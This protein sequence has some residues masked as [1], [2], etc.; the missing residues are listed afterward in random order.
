MDHRKT[1]REY[2]R[3]S[4]L[5]GEAAGISG[6]YKTNKQLHNNYRSLAFVYELAAHKHS[7]LHHELNYGTDPE[8]LNF[9]KLD[10]QHSDNYLKRLHNERHDILNNHNLHNEH[11]KIMYQAEENL[12][13]QRY[14]KGWR[15]RMRLESLC[16]DKSKID[17]YQ[18]LSDHYYYAGS[19]AAPKI[20]SRHRQKN[21]V[22][23]R[24]ESNNLD[25]AHHYFNAAESFH[26]AKEAVLA[27]KTDRE[28]HHRDKGM[29]HIRKMKKLIN[30]EPETYKW[31]HR[32]FMKRAASAV[33]FFAKIDNINPSRR[34]ARL[35]EDKDE[36][37]DNLRKKRDHYHE[38]SFLAYDDADKRASSGRWEFEYHPIYSDDDDDLADHYERIANRYNGAIE[39]HLLGNH[40]RSKIEE[41]GAERSISRLN[42]FLNDTGKHDEHKE[43]MRL[44]KRAAE[45]KDKMDDLPNRPRRR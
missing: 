22:L 36:R 33:K 9:A 3:K 35:G 39:H 14:S 8:A 5:Y 2:L 24:D 27:G 31:R 12:I 16:E 6:T 42:I 15:R 37:L 43:Y 17:K 38:A 1:A 40:K 44:G 26:N 23:S 41:A 18:H 11:D 32:D 21:D 34:R 10:T 28:I 30:S 29:Y 7:N 20:H 25:L 45:L 19:L 13:N 4:K